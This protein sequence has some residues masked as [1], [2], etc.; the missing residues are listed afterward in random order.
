MPAHLT[1]HVVDLPSHLTPADLA[2]RAVAV[3]DVLRATT[4]ITQAIAAGTAA[5]HLFDTPAAASAT[6]KA[7]ANAS[8]VSV[9]LA[10]EIRCL[11]APGFDLGNSPSHF[12][13]AKV[14]RQTIHFATTNGTRAL[15]AASAAPIVIAACLN[16]AQAAA[17]YLHATGLPITLLA[18]GTHG[19]P[20]QEDIAGCG[21]VAHY[22]HQSGHPPTPAAQAAI[23]LFQKWQ[24]DLPTLLRSTPGGQNIQAAGLPEDITFAAQL[25]TTT[26]VARLTPPNTLIRA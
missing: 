15:L 19:E 3:F 21:A 2:G 26:A 9:L 20:A 8:T 4:T 13:P 10:G 16:N 18:A 6:A 17:R 5:I 25:N 7:A 22:L 24:H 11:P 14:A 23:D 12:T 1:L